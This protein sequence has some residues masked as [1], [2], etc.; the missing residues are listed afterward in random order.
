MFVS[1]EL[2]IHSQMQFP[3][4]PCGQVSVPN[5]I[6]GTRSKGDLLM[7]EG[8][9]EKDGTNIQARFNGPDFA[10]IED[11]RR[12]QPKI[13]TLTETVRKLVKLGLVEAERQ[14]RNT[15]H[16]SKPATL[17]EVAGCFILRAET[18]LSPQGQE[19]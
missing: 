6:V 1:M 12:L 9:A 11:W 8:A 5:G 18:S 13:P 19:M 4:F 17:E 2:F 7:S 14:P 15:L 16:K 10:R 3:R